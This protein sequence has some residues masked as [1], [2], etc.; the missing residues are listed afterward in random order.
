M[1]DDF[2]HPCETTTGD[3]PL[4][5][6]CIDLTGDLCNGALDESGYRRLD[7][8][9]GLRPDLAE[10][11]VEVTNLHAGLVLQHASLAPESF[12]EILERDLETSE[13]VDSNST[14]DLSERFPAE[15]RFARLSRQA[16]QFVARPTPLS[17]AASVLIVAAALLTLSVVRLGRVDPNDDSPIAQID[18]RTRP[19]A[20]YLSEAV[21][22]RWADGGKPLEPGQLLYEGDA[23]ALESGYVQITFENGAQAL[24]EGPVRFLATKNDRGQLMRGK[25]AVLAP[26]E[27]RGFTVETPAVKVVDLGT[28]FCA[29]VA[30]DGSTDVHV[31]EGKVQATSIR[32]DGVAARRMI[33]SANEAARFFLHGGRVE[34]QIADA[35]RFRQP[36]DSLARGKLVIP[37]AYVRAV[38]A[39]RPAVY[40][41]FER[42]DGAVTRNEMENRYHA[43]IVGMVALDGDEK[44]RSAKF[45]GDDSVDRYLVSDRAVPGLTG[46]QYTIEIW[47]RAEQWD[48]VAIVGL[49]SVDT[50]KE[51]Q[52]GRYSDLRLISSAGENRLQFSHQHDF[53]AIRRSTRLASSAT[54]NDRSWRHIVARRDG[55]ELAMFVDGRLS[56]KTDV[57]PAV[58]DQNCFVVV[59]KR[60]PNDDL[61]HMYFN[62]ELDELALYGRALSDAE[63]VDHFQQARRTSRLPVAHPN[64]PKQ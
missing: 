7:E 39:S 58:L 48:K 35:S 27:A 28:R 11:Y 34:P 12:A 14:R 56:A 18:G 36:V 33:L 40:W 47:V 37:S 38:K 30:A 61:P 31:I 24:L 21:D 59:G 44:N 20:A 45:R 17:I 19:V 63:I 55:K 1:N 62:G 8:L 9:L 50:I 41:R 54:Y 25:I 60:R 52:G 29:E 53:D 16:Y 32:D 46:S 42:I 22:C 57:S 64:N 5:A 6:E 43:R 13:A 10:H 2:K 49:L 3:D 4:V 15:S 26:R 51:I 23:V